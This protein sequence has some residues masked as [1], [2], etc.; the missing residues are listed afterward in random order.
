M[1][2]P[3]SDSWDTRDALG[4]E[5]GGH[6]HHEDRSRDGHENSDDGGVGALLADLGCVLPGAAAQ[7]LDP[8]RC[9]DAVRAAHRLTAI[10]QSA[11]MLATGQLAARTGERLLRE[12]DAADPGE[13]SKT[14]R[15]RW[16]ARVKTVTALE[17]EARTGLGRYAARELVALATAPAPVRAAVTQGLSGGTT[18]AEQV[19]AWW[20]RCSQLPHEDATDIARRLFADSD[21]PD[22]VVPERRGPDGDVKTAPWA[23]GEFRNALEREATRAEGRDPTTR[24]ATRAARARARDGYGILDDDGTGRVVLTGDAASVSAC[25]DRLHVLA[26]RARQAGDPR[27][28]A[29]LRSD[30]GR[31]LLLHGTLPL[32]DLGDEPALIT[33][34]DIDRLVQVVSGAPSYEVQVVVPWNALTGTPALATINPP[35]AHWHRAETGTPASNPEGAAAAAA[36]TTPAAAATD[37]DEFGAVPAG[38]VGEQLGRF[39]RY[40]TTDEIRDILCR[41]RT[42]LFRLLTDP[43]DGRCVERTLARYQPDAAMRAQVRAADLTSRGPGSTVLVR[44]ADL[45][46]VTSYLL[47]GS[48]NEVNLQGLDRVWH[49]AKTQKHWQAQIDATR[50]VTW[51]SLWGRLYRTRGHDYSQYLDL[52]SLAG[53]A[54]GSDPHEPASHA[55][56]SGTSGRPGTD[57]TPEERRHLASLLVY[58]ALAHRDPGSPLESDTDD[59]DNDGDL[60]DVRR[61]RQAIHLRHTRPDGKKGNGPHPRTP[62]PGQLRQHGASTVL[63]HSEWTLLRHTTPGGDADNPDERGANQPPPPF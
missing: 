23:T 3:P 6:A 8:E 22:D 13:L 53:P 17:V 12:A 14:A 10:L 27:T 34:D 44:D 49:A 31:A 51:T 62:T 33:P 35:P 9:L 38:G 28:Q 29:Q 41:T 25:V 30:V 32:P 5:N 36:R 55:G 60:P 59:P 11:T 47:G 40:L 24:A 43:A 7:D 39:R 19:S 16:R 54:P 15:A 42:S 26:R 37:R 52:R 1:T 63:N 50:N 2:L 46:H 21:D 57:L 48:T 56:P 61:L 20:R 4:D 45:D 58:S 18:R